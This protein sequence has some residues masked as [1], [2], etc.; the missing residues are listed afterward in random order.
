[1]TQSTSAAFPSLPREPSRLSR[2]LLW[3]GAALAIG[4]GML[5]ECYPLGSLARA[6]LAEIPLSGPGFRGWNV[7]LT[8]AEQTVLGRV[9]LINRGYWMGRR[10]LFISVVDGT[11]D[12]H[13]VHDPRYC[14]QGAGWTLTSENRVALP[15]GD[16]M[17]L[18][19]RR[20]DDRFDVLYWFADGAE[21]Y[22]AFPRYWWQTTLRRLSLGRLG[23]EPLLVVVQDLDAD[24]TVA[25]VPARQVI[26][27]L[28]L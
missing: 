5:W 28:K 12:R 23:S 15:G 7:A 20:A 4:C 13:A 25:P 24:G 14:F 10:R 3:I 21:R 2:R 22:A 8:P 17:R 27:A 1:M 9:D 19:L 16:G 18:T 11:K 6:R 26:D